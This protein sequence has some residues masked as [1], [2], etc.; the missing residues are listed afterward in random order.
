MRIV[1]EVLDGTRQLECIHG[2]LLYLFFIS[3]RVWGE[4]VIVVEVMVIS[5]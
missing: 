5:I 2:D 3:V 1:C 4:E